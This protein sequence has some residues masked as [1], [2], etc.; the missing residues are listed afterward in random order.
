MRRFCV[1][2]MLDWTDRYCRYFL[3]LLS[4]H[5]LLYTEMVT[6]AALQHGDIRRHLEFDP[7][8]QPVALQLGGSNPRELAV[9][10]RLAASYG[11]AEVNF[12][13]GC[14]SARV[15]AGRFG[16]CLMKESRLVRD[17]MAAMKHATDIPVTIKHRLG[18]D[19]CDG[20]SQLVDFV[21][22]LAAAGC[23]TF[24]IHARK[25]WLNG[26]SPKQNRDIP[27]L[28]HDHV[29]RIKR[30]FP[31]LEIILNG[32]INELAEAGHHLRSVDGVMVGRAAYH[33]PYLLADVDRVLF[34]DHHPVPSRSEVL[35]QY[36]AFC[37]AQISARGIRFSHLSRHVLG[38][39]QGQPGARQFRRQLSEN[40]HRPD[41]G[42]QLLQDAV[43]AMRSDP[44][45]VAA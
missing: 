12:N 6:S 22:T 27:P 40:A 35:D 19:D 9:G 3:R 20:Y 21:G 14:P 39:F 29:Y 7:R 36:A 23:T 32:G 11:Y 16:A 18:V 28:R 38:L 37:A 43:D 17:C 13:C 1:A 44:A 10:A 8:E 34:D 2:P 30:D 45:S 33:N 26:L 5:A 42:I 15:Q 31:D 4:R 41:A 25:A 24:I